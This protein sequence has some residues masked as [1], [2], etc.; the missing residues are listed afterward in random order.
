V[1]ITRRE[2]GTVA[3]MGSYITSLVLAPHPVSSPFD[4]VGSSVFLF[5][6]L[7]KDLI[8]MRFAPDTNVKIAGTSW[9]LTLD[10][11][12]LRL[13][14]NLT[15]T[16]GPMHQSQWWLYVG[17][18]C[19]YATKVSHIHQSQRKVLNVRVP[20]TLFLKLFYFPLENL[21]FVQKRA[22]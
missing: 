11:F 12:F 3:G 6:P 2:I 17:L 7:K 21:C 9:L 10:T 20:F 1:P 14:T 4:S 22:A 5:E 8:G 15:A 16:E 19:N 18:M 13:Y